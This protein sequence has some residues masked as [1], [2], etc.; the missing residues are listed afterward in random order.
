M[1]RHAST[2]I[3]QATLYRDS[4]RM[5]AGLDEARRLQKAEPKSPAGFG[6]EAEILAQ[7]KQYGPAVAAY[8]SA[9]ALGWV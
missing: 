4:G 1:P 7:D 3:A 2:W 5:A 9:I 6:L 8:R